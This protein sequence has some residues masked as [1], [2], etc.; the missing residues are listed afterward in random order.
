MAVTSKAMT[1]AV[2]GAM[3]AQNLTTPSG[4]A[5]FG[6]DQYVIRLNSTPEAIGALNQ[7]EINIGDREAEVVA[8]GAGDD[9]S[10][11]PDDLAF[12]RALHGFPVHARFSDQPVEIGALDH[13][14]DAVGGDHVDA[15]FRRTRRN[16]QMRL[17]QS[18]GTERIEDD[19]GIL[20]GERAGR[21]RDQP[22]HAR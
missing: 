16:V 9:L 19:V 3:T 7:A 21:L 17:V 5:K 13:V 14:A 2:T 11:R 1:I 22:V 12:A 10:V 6:P 20:A 8:R 4:L 15:V 18:V